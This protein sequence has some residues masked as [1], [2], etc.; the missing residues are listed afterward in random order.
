MNKCEECDALN[1]QVSYII[2]QKN[3]EVKKLE[4]LK[5]NYYSIRAD[6]NKLKSEYQDFREFTQENEKKLLGDLNK[7]NK[8]L[9]IMN[10]QNSVIQKDLS[11]NLNDQK[12][13]NSNLRKQIDD[14]L[15]D[16]SAEID[17]PSHNLKLDRDC[18]RSE[19]EFKDEM[20]DLMNDNQELVNMNQ[21]WADKLQENS[22]MNH[23]K[24]F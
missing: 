15:K 18:L 20:E 22:S 11:K 24:R 2:E 19:H 7:V 3:E 14:I 6:N 17:P 12:I 8:E 21:F 10:S 16:H 13:I 23:G 1:N 9:K 4:S 5:R